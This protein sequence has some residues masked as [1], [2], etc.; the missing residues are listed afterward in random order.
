MPTTAVCTPVNSS[1]APVKS[2]E[3]ALAPDVSINAEPVTAPTN[4]ASLKRETRV[5]FFAI[6]LQ[7]VVFP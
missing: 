2:K 7:L 4:A 1:D 3:A 5:G 6:Q